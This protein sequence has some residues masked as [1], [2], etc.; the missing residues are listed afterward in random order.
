MK[1]VLIIGSTG[2]LG[3]QVYFRLKKSNKYIVQDI[4]YRNK[5]NEN[6]IL[7]DVSN[8]ERLNEIITNEAPDFIINCVGILIN[9]ANNDNKNAILINSY[10]PHWLRD[11]SNENGSQLIHVST[12]CVFSGS[13][14]EYVESDT[15]DATDVYGKTKSLGEINDDKN[16]TLR[17]SIIGP[18]LKNNG[19][20]LFHWFM[21]QKNQIKGY[22]KAFWGGVTTTE[23]AK[24][25]E[26]VIENN[27][28]GLV[29]VS[30][31]TKISKFDLLNVINYAFTKNIEILAHENKVVDKSLKSERKD[32]AF[33]VLSYEDQITEMKNFMEENRMLYKDL[34]EF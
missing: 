2:M 29:H 10:F 11:V 33:K 22:T 4:S 26:Y 19:E 31:G 3:H 27:I 21:N 17:T 6:T 28:T 32:F 14:G 18:E 12:D 8:F 9:G 25:I 1:K 13:K 30:N 34:Y 24:T 16:L 23:L 7:C 20:G 5:L 15:C